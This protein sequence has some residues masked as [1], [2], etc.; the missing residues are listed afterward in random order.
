MLKGLLKNKIVKNANWLIGTRIARILL[1]FVVAVLT[2]RFLGPDNYGVINYGAAY[3]AFFINLCNLGINAILVKEFT[4]K[5]YSEGEVLGTTLTLRAVAS[6]LSALVIVIMTLFFDRDDKT[7]LWVTIICG[8]GVVFYFFDSFSYWFQSKLQSKITGIA[9]LVAYIA[10]SLYKIILLIL[11]KSVFWFAFA[12]TVEYISVA[13]V[14]LIA[15]K[16]YKGERLHASF[17]CAKHLLSKSYHFILPNMMI[18]IYQYADKFMLKQMMNSTENGFYSTAVAASTMW[19]F[20]LAAIIDSLYPSIMEL[21]KKD[22]EAY[23]KRNKQMYAVVIYIS[24]FVS[25]GIMIFG[26]WGVNLIYGE[27]FLPAAKPLNIVTWY[28]AFSYLGTARNA[29]IVCENKQKYLKYIYIFSALANVGLNYLLIP[30]WGAS[31]AAVAS[32]V[33][34]ASTILIP[35]AI[36]PLRHNVKLMFEALILKNV[37]PTK[38]GK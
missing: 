1:S 5:T 35:I 24:I 30:L 14:F 9:G 18:V 17:A 37:L 31:G 10:I 6:I 28:T 13:V 26:R 2:T 38:E 8:S 7:A 23:E 16:C 3:A 15:Y 12:S 22:Y 21:Y 20:V 34:Q 19:G 32:L 4:D 27:E 29:W 36:K 11:Q 25:I 33:T